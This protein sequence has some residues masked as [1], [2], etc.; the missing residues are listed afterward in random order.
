VILVSVVAVAAVAGW[1][2]LDRVAGGHAASA[3]GQVSG[4]REEWSAAVCTDGTVST[5][6]DG[7]A[8]FPN[9]ENYASC[10]SRVPGSGGGVVPILIGEW[11]DKLTMHQDLMHYKAIRSFASA[12]RAD[13]VIVFAPI[14]DT[15][16]APLEPLTEF[17]FSIAPLP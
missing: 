7:K 5:I 13:T 17:G 6:S 12:E 10:M 9:V 3:A 15:G 4:D 2:D 14:G 16:P 11:N 1:I 8:G